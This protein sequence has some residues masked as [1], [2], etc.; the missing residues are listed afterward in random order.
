MLHQHLLFLDATCHA[1]TITGL[2][3]YRMKDKSA[4][5]GLTNLDTSARDTSDGDAA[6][7]IPPTAAT[8]SI[9]DLY[10]STQRYVM[11]AAVAFVSIIVP[12][13]DTV[14][15][16]ALQ[17]GFDPLYKHHSISGKP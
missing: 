16:P 2:S 8:S 9:Y 13:S 1:A 15:L 10:S 3:T 5:N 6:V 4:L 14:Y 12:F 7:V 17:V 11:L